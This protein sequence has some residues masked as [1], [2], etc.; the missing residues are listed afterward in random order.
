M[1][2]T[3]K[4]LLVWFLGQP[5]ANFLSRGLATLIEASKI[6]FTCPSR[7][8]VWSLLVNLLSNQISSLL[9]EPVGSYKRAA[10]CD[11]PQYFKI[12]WPCMVGVQIGFGIMTDSSL[13]EKNV[14][15]KLIKLRPPWFMRLRRLPV[16]ITAKLP[17]V[18][19]A[20]FLSMDSDW[21]MIGLAENHSDGSF[22]RWISENSDSQSY[23]DSAALQDYCKT[24]SS[25][26]Y[27]L[28]S[29]QVSETHLCH[30]I[31]HLFHFLRDV[32]G[33]AGV[34]QGWL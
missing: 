22:T 25:S 4:Q 12:S 30:S 34:V 3:F 16:F 5:I 26:A 18:A 8:E 11:V 1:H 27:V 28:I 31:C 17:A 29:H 7:K 19:S 23:G 2:I 9:A 24:S 20:S 32:A 33:G 14:L 10:S 6:N 21:S 13:T 15:F